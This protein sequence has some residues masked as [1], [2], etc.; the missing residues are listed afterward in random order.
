[1]HMSFGVLYFTFL[2]QNT[3]VTRMSHFDYVTIEDLENIG[4]GKPGARRL[5]EAVKKR[6]TKLKSKNLVNKILPASIS[7]SKL[8]KTTSSGSVKKTSSNI[9]FQPGVSLTCL[10]QEKVKYISSP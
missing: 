7:Q 9:E 1:M 3:Q 2:C 6:K 10:I 8:P 5:I 4:M